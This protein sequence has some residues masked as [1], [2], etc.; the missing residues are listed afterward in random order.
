MYLTLAKGKDFLVNLIMNTDLHEKQMIFL[1]S[2]F[3]TNFSDKR[4][5]VSLFIEGK[6]EVGRILYTT[7]HGSFNSECPKL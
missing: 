4:H 6:S 3:P 2:L 1:F 5:M 7:I